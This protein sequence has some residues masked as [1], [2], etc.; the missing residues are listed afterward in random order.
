MANSL[1]NDWDNVVAPVRNELV[2]EGRNKDYGAFE[3]RKN[4]NKDSL[5]IVSGNTFKLSL[6]ELRLVFV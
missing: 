5:L 6:T 3:M 1:F 2:F 4:H